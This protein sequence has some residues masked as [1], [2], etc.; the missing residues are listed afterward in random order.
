MNKTVACIGLAAAL[1]SV[2]AADWS[3][4][5]WISVREAPVHDG[6]RSELAAPG[7]SW[8][9]RS[10]VNAGEIA[11]AKWTVAGLG[12]FE[13]YVN[14]TRV[15]DDFLKPGFTHNKKT[16]YAFTYDVTDLLKKDE[17]AANVLAAEVSSGWW[18]DKVC[19]PDHKRYAG[20]KSA[21]RGELE[22][23]YADGRRETIGT[24]AADW[25][26]GIAGPVVRAG[27]FDGEI[28][29]A[30]KSAP[31]DGKGLTG[32][33]EANDEFPGEILPTAGAEVTLR[34]DLAMTRGPFALKKGETLV[35]DFGQ[36][37]AGVPEFRFRAPRGTVLTALPG[38]MLNDA[39]KGRR[40]SDGPEGSVYRA[41]LRMADRG[42]RIDYTFA[43]EGVETYLP[44]FT[45]FG[46]RYM[47]VTATDDVE[48][49]S[50]ASIPVTSITKEMETG[51]LEVGDKDLAKFISNVYWGQLSNYLSVPTDCPQRNERL[52]WTAD[53]QVFC[54]A[55]TY[56]ADTLRFFRKYTR[57]LRDSQDAEGGYPSVAPFAQYGNETF[58]L[59]W[60]D[61]GVIVPWTVW[62]QFGDQKIL[63]DNWDAM[64]KFVRKLDETK[65]DFEGKIGFIYADWLSYEKFE[66]CGNQYG[67]W[68]SKWGKDPDAMN[69]RR[70]LAACYWLYDAQ[71]MA[72][73]GDALEK[74]EE[75]A[76]FRA[77]AGRAREYIRGRFLEKD[78]LLLKP[79]RDLQTACV[80][81][82]KFD[83][84]EGAARTATKDLLL[85][86]IREHGD[87][88]QTGFLGTSFLMEVLAKENEFD[89]AYTLLFQHRNPSWLYSVDQGATTVW[90]RWNSY[91]KKDGFGDVGM[92][93]FNHYAYG[94][95]LAWIYRHAAGIACDSSAPGFK[96]I[97]MAPKPDRRLGFVR[98]S[99]RSA[100]GLITSA[101]RYAG[102]DWTW[103]F[104]IPEGAVGVVTVP[105]RAL[106]EYPSG[107]HRV[108]VRLPEPAKQG[109]IRTSG[110]DLVDEKGNKFFIRG[111]N[112]GN[113]L[114]PEGYMFGFGKC[115]SAHMIDEAFRELVGPEEAAKFWKAFKDNYVTEK[116]IAFIAETGANT[117]RLPFH[118]KLFTDEDYLG[119]TG[120]GDGFARI[121]ALVAWCRKHGLRLILDMH[122]CPG[123][124]TGDN[125]DDSYGYPWLFESAHFQKQYCDIWRA[126]AARYA[127]EPVVLGYEFMNEPISS[128]LSDMAEIN[129]HLERVQQMAAKAIREVDKNHVLIFGGAQWNSNFE[130]FTDYRF[131][132]NMMYTCHHYAFGNPNYDDGQVSRHA[133]FRDKS[134]VPMFMGE[135][136]HNTPGWIKAITESMEQKNIGWTFWPFKKQ[137]GDCWFCFKLPDGWKEIVVAFA[138]ADRSSYEAIQKNRP[139]RAKAVKLLQEYAENCRF[140]N[141]RAV[142]EYLKANG[143]KVPASK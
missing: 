36:N 82:L 87:C 100:A 54:E 53:T 141:C 94:A 33:T 7:T 90:E 132:P 84:V 16:K 28:Y 35:V 73:M 46:Y 95:V 10:F 103:D 124:Q 68:H 40:G 14:G 76:W 44:R 13:A 8:F 34:R 25:K 98:A 114:N 11:S 115:N 106:A 56:N 122:D 116:D 38:E 136:G 85:K 59:G 88:L 39:G 17:G 65:Y 75:A 133:A 89:V 128:R 108:T 12:V 137:S 97:V 125:I 77:S 111:T 20:V 86:S 123:G 70:F 129:K 42:M 24:K 6:S 47:S 78:G 120:P 91:T 93:S 4:S 49:E 69:Y 83:V 74:A 30:R 117:V 107:S 61:A 105:G 131:D 60:A 5:E 18:R 104:T 58:K 43:G 63:I 99:Y 21:F 50:V 81:A 27:I 62:K 92:N 130:P 126:I 9:A 1:Q 37:C 80:F 109:F 118:Y 135:T 31:L 45:F 79:M 134:G 64:A 71:L 127:D 41:N 48:I 138:E 52:G 140:E 51:K 143:L 96:K 121:D 29:D 110:H 23:V 139:D 19:S 72:E 112:L 15:G 2:A 66:T 142:P 26:S 22:L 3:K 32:T 57:D 101:W 55:G 119:L 113:W 67:S 102:D